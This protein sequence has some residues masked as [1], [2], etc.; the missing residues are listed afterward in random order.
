MAR[1]SQPG[2]EK[3]TPEGAGREPRRAGRFMAWLG[4]GVENEADSPG[5]GKAEDTAA[6]EP[7]PTEVDVSED[8]TASQPEPT[9]PQREPARAMPDPPP[10]EEWQVPMQTAGPAA[11]PE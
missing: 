6:T 10:T 2:S 4:Y 8:K 7:E 5:E 3:A 9:K 1:R 11:P